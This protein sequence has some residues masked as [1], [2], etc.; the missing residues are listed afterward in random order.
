MSYPEQPACWSWP[1]PP[2]RDA[3]EEIERHLALMAG[4]ARDH[5]LDRSALEMVYGGMV[6]MAT[7]RYIELHTGARDMLG[8][9]QVRCALCGKRSVVTVED[10]DH[11]TGLVRGY[12]CPGCNVLEGRSTDPLYDAYRWKH[13]ARILGYRAF[14]VGAPRWPLGWWEDEERAR[15]LT[16]NPRWTRETVC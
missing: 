6:S 4:L 15:E 8:P 7:N 10:H 2:L 1:V 11:R 16:G 3:A 13:P 12:L 14:Y 5:Q 9:V